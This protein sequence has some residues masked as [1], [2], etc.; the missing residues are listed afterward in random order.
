MKL[1]RTKPPYGVGSCAVLHNRSALSTARQWLGKGNMPCWSHSCHPSV[2]LGPLLATKV[3]VNQFRKLCRGS[4]LYFLTPDCSTP[5]V[6]AS[7]PCGRKLSSSGCLPC[8]VCLSPLLLAVGLNCQQL[9]QG[10]AWLFSC[11]FLT[12]LILLWLPVLTAGAVRL[13]QRNCQP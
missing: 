4:P 6:P 1:C 10:A 8:P 9:P 13:W 2:W 3:S 7:L 11:S 5:S 12:A